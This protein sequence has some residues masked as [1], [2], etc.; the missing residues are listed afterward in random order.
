[1]CSVAVEG[2]EGGYLTLFCIIGKV[3]KLCQ[4]AES[5]QAAKLISSI[6]LVVNGGAVFDIHNTHCILVYNVNSAYHACKC[7]YVW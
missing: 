2:G 3:P 4:K 5:M 6:Y 1:M 7:Y